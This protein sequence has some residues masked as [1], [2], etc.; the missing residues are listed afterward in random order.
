MKKPFLKDD[1][2]LQAVRDS[3]PVDEH[4]VIWWLGQSGFLICSSR[5][6]LL[7]DPYLSESLTEKYASTD[8]PHVRITERVMDP[9]RLDFIDVVTS[10]HNHTDHLD[11]ETLNPLRKAN[12]NLKMVIPE[13]NR[14]F[15][16]QRLGCESDWPLGLSDGESLT[17]GPFQIHAVPAA[18]ESI[19]RD[20]RGFSHYL[21]YV[22]EIGPWTIYHS[23]DTM[24]F[25]G[26]EDI[27]RPFGIDIAIL[28]ING[29]RPER[30]VAGNLDGRQAATLAHDIGATVAIPCHYDMFEF[31]TESPEL[32]E[33]T[34]AGL[35]QKTKTLLNGQ[36]FSTTAMTPKKG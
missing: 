17:A 10:S 1:A 22:A 33:S 20:D 7:F 11:A 36:S 32:F 27:L 5:G 13:A 21:G 15:V 26:M 29:R 14:H 8:K 18:H 30:H 23:G 31:N 2:L 12:P 6:T 3:M 25:D 24:H 4:L 34:A 9:G 19:D 28:P 16:C 35:G